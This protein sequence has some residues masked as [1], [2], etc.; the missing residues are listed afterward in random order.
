MRGTHISNHRIVQQRRFRD[1]LECELETVK[2]LTART[3]LVRRHSVWEWYQCGRQGVRVP[4]ESEVQRVG[5]L[6]MCSGCTLPV[7]GGIISKRPIDRLNSH[8]GE[9]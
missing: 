3:G 7:V 4:D 9:Q 8:Y 1:G 2:V 5:G 6:Q